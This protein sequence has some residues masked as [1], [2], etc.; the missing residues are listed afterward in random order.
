MV[1]SVGAAPGALSAPSAHGECSDHRH[2]AQ[3]SLRSLQVKMQPVQNLHLI[4]L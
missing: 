2:E 1:L 3:Y 4:A